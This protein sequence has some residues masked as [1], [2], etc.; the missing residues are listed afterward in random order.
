M[1]SMLDSPWVGQNFSPP[2][3]LDI[4]TIEGAIVSQ[5][6]S[7][8][9]AALGPQ[10]I[11]VIHFPDKPESYEMRHRIGVA[12][13]IYMGSVFGPIID[14]GH[15][16]QERTME[17]AVG[18][19]IRDLGWSYG[20]PPSGP[21]PGAY[22]IIEAVRLALLGYQPNRGCTPIKAMRERFLE[23]D[24]QGGVWVYESTFSTRTV[25]VETT[26]RRITRCSLTARRWRSRA[27]DGGIGVRP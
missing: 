3:A 9:T 27:D 8:F 13:V 26:L 18:L 7:Y 20:G 21:S 11:E 19:R 25:A 17:F 23:R 15:V 4:A 22:Q 16:V 1:A 6:Q 14:T 24:R 2:T 5:L 10:M 12:M